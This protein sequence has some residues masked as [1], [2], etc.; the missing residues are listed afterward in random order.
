MGNKKY[1][2]RGSKIEYLINYLGSHKNSKKKTL[3]GCIIQKIENSV[4]IYPENQWNNFKLTQI[5]TC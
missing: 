3:S 4:V 1:Y 5:D 2:A